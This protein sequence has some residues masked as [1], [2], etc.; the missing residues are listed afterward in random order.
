MHA[1]ER[2][3]IIQ[4]YLEENG[5]ARVHTLSRILGVSEVT[6]RRDLERLE[7]K[8]WLSRT[9]GG[10]VIEETSFLGRSFEPTGSRCP[11]PMLAQIAEIALRMIEDGET[12]MLMDGPTCTQIGHRLTDRSNL[13]VL[14]NSLAVAD[15]VSQQ[16]T[17]RVVLLGGEMDAHE[18][19]VFGSMA[20][21][22][23]RRFFVA[24]LFVE[25]EG[26]NDDL[27][28]SVSSQVK[29]D[30]IHSL[31]GASMHTTVIC[32]PDRFSFNAFARLDSLTAA[33]ALI[34]APSVEDAHKT[35]I[36][37]Q[38]IPLFTSVVVFEGPP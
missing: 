3:R 31:M 14:T 7:A 33:D 28:M 16:P 11:E 38:G 9:H 4:Q 13:T 26:I 12:V 17:N 15:T 35:R 29:A 30:L 21:E 34:T 25:V 27:E 2:S 10:A 6:V 24:R 32:L 37:E 23:V 5:Q 1:V 36:F 19:A 8:G 18:K 22:N 20:I